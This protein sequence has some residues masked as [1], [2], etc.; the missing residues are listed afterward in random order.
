MSAVEPVEEICSF[1]TFNIGVK[2]M[3]N[4][5]LKTLKFPNHT[6]SHFDS[7]FIEKNG[8]LELN[9]KFIT[10][11]FLTA[12]TFETH[13]YGEQVAIDHFVLTFPSRTELENYAK[14]FYPFGAKTVEGPDLFP[15][16]FCA[17]NINVPSDLWLHLMT[18]LMP[19]G[20]LVVL[21]APHA[22]GDQT[23]RFQQER[24]LEAVH[25]VAI[26]VENVQNAAKIWQNKNFKPLS[27]H[28]LNSGSLTQWFLQNPAGQILELIERR[29]GNNAT[30]DCKNIAGL[31]LSEVASQ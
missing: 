27:E 28:P 8:L 31:R 21:D 30:F 12:W 19:A 26:R 4:F 2:H 15:I 22:P 1:A 6:D 23:D 17:E 20:G 18:L 7:P 25:H 14:S 9:P 24:G 29:P 16:N 10:P 13:L 5:K 11:E 3:K